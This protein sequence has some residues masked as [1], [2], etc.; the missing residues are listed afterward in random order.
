MKKPIALGA[1]LMCGALL[2]S[3]S[4]LAQ[5]DTI[6][7]YPPQGAAPAG[8]PPAYPYGAPVSGAPYG[9]PVYSAAVPPPGAPQNLAPNILPA[10]DKGLGGY[11]FNQPAPPPPGYAGP[12]AFA[13][14]GEL[15]GQLFAEEFTGGVGMASAYA[16]SGGGGGG[17]GFFF[18]SSHGVAPGMVGQAR[19]VGV[20]RLAAGVNRAIAGGHGGHFSGGHFGFGGGG[21]GFGFGGGGFAGGFG[22]GF[23][24][25]GFGGR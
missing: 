10:P 19:A 18:A 5:P 7:L 24:G 12:P 22:G 13:A 21:F 4:A 16:A 15:N 23:G 6:Y 11:T 3:G 9:A 17:G 1:A 20:A 25:G 8:A 14:T 2:S